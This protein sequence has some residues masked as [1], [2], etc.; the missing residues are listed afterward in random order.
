MKRDFKVQLDKSKRS[1]RL[2]IMRVAF[3]ICALLIV[4]RLVKLQIIDHSFYEDLAL[5]QHNI[6]QQL[7][8]ERGSIYVHDSENSKDLYPL[9]SNQ[10]LTLVY[11]QP[12][13]IE[14]PE[15]TAE[16]ITDILFPV[17]EK[18]LNIDLL[19]IE[20]QIEEQGL[21]KEEVEAELKKMAGEE[22]RQEKIK[23][24]EEKFS[25]K[26]DPYEPLKHRVDDET[27][28]QIKKL[29]LKGI[30][31]AKEISRLYPENNLASQILGFVNP[32]LEEPG[33]YGIEGFF[34][35]ELTGTKGHLKSEMDPYGRWIATTDKE[36]VEA[37]D[38]ISYVLTIDK[39]IQ[40]FAEQRLKEAVLLHKA[41]KGSVVILDPNTGAVIAMANYPDFNPNEYNKTENLDAFNNSAI[42][43]AYEPGSIF[44]AITMAMALDMEKVNPNTTYVDEGTIK[45]GD[46]KISNFDNQAHGVTTM[47]QVLESSLNLGAIFASEQ[48]G[49]DN[50]K[51]YVEDF[52]FGKITG[53][54]LETEKAGNISSLDKPGEIYTATASFGQGI[55]VTALQMAA[56]YNALANGGKLMA[57]YIVE[58]EIS[59]SGEVTEKQPQVIRQVISQR[60]ATLLSGMLVSVL[61]NGHSKA[62]KVPGYYVAGKTGTAQVADPATGRYSSDTIHSF[63]GFAPVDNPRFVMI[64]RLDKPQASYAET[65]CAPLFS[66]IAKFVLDYYHVPPEREQ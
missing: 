17:E 54:E 44:K 50:F 30:S 63:I 19:S 37:K 33:Q 39:N 15:E 58:K 51:K 2:I 55:T 47:T 5:G 45:Y 1:P 20:N 23:E 29:E 38:G 22:K 52:G 48:V 35:K 24:L 41:E 42:F 66:E 27:V 12:N 3:S 4:F 28:D 13:K 43:E 46:K 18:D 61:E 49:K 36:F 56:A 57:P 6:F 32:N 31:F 60:A 40:Y 34:N 8:P 10:D 62:A 9:A 59:N 26:D 16:K 25:H 64:T 14:N 11:A 65:T 7:Y 53:I 21:D